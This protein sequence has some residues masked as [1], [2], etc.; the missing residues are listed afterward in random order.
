MLKCVCEDIQKTCELLV[1]LWEIRC[2]NSAMDSL[3]AFVEKTKA[4]QRDCEML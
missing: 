2:V 4:T 3:L 1:L